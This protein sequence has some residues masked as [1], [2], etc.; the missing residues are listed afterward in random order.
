MTSVCQHTF[1][2]SVIKSL[3]CRSHSCVR[4]W[5]C[6][7]ELLQVGKLG[8]LVYKT[9]G[10]DFQVLAGSASFLYPALTVGEPFI[11]LAVATESY[12]QL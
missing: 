8:N 7:L 2:H 9:R 11:C 6:L 3:H 1:T 5:S 4:V 12:E 10:D